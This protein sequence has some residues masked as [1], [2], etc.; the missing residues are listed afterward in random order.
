MADRSNEM[1][2][3]ADRSNE[4]RL[5]A[6]LMADRCNEIRLR[7]AHRNDR[8]YDKEIEKLNLVFVVFY[9]FLICFWLTHVT[10]PVHWRSGEYIQKEHIP[11]IIAPCHQQKIDRSKET[12]EIP[13]NLSNV[14]VKSNNPSKK[15]R[16]P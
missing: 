5:M 2:L 8:F 16:E 10:Y 9:Y 14:S 15:P 1:R 7:A 3:M 11:K 6:R 13:T 4:M 12:K